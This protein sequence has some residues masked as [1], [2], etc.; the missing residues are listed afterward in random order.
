MVHGLQLLLRKVVDLLALLATDHLE[1]VQV[2]V[3]VVEVCHLHSIEDLVVDADQ[4]QA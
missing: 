2:E 3:V 4:L 1:V